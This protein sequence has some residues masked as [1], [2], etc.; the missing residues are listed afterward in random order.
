MSAATWLFDG[1]LGLLLVALALASLHARDLYTSVSLFIAFGVVAALAWAYLGAPDL[2][3]AEAAISAGLTGVLLIAALA[4]IGE[5][6]PDAL[7]RRPLATLLPLGAL[8]LLIASLWPLAGARS[9]LPALL[10]EHLPQTGLRNPVTGVLLNFRAW[11][12]LLEILVLLIA[13]VGSCGL[14]PA[15]AEA[16][17]PWRLLTAWSR[18]LVPLLAL[19]GIY[20]L[21]RGSD[22]PGGA[23]QAGALL[24][25]G[26][27][28]LRLTGQLPESDW[29]NPLVRA[30]A[31]SG[32]LLFS[33]IAAL[34][35]WLGAGWLDYPADLD[36]ATAVVIEVFA[37]V[38]ITVIL[39]LLVAGSSKELEP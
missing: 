9:V 6:A 10:S 23:F 15:P 32:L 39:T 3:L 28:L 24:A 12:T 1:L 34:T 27:V 35:A 29:R 19:F 13:L 14:R 5:G 2:A 25:A 31:V 11:D 18:L 38:S 33:V 22:W 36:K 16:P 37:T 7:H 20:L 21:W 26:A 4:R 30:L 8:V 17:A